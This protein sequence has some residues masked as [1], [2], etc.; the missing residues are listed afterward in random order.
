MTTLITTHNPGY[1][2]P[3]TGGEVLDLGILDTEENTITKPP[4]VWRLPTHV[5]VGIQLI[6]QWTSE[7]SELEYIEDGASKGVIPAHAP[8]SY[9]PESRA[10]VQAGVAEAIQF[11]YRGH[12]Q[13]IYLDGGKETVYGE[14]WCGATLQLAS[15]NILFRKPFSALPVGKH[16]CTVVREGAQFR[17]T[18]PGALN[19]WPRY[20]LGGYYAPQADVTQMEQLYVTMDQ[21]DGHTVAHAERSSAYFHRYG[22]YPP[23]PIPSGASHIVFVH[24]A[25]PLQQLSVA[26]AIIQGRVSLVIQTG[27]IAH[28]FTSLSY[29]TISSS[30]L[31]VVFEFRGSGA[32]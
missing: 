32:S 31:E 12:A 21:V 30:C 14:T 2:A 25:D 5:R 9:K 24:A 3:S 29:E 17:V 15:G 8:E 7:R 20:A 18:P 16:V 23:A 13:L 19:H 28:H 1:T 27:D 22:L 26:E 10:L 11:H 6:P 4:T